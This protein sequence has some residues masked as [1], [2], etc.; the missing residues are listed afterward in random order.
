VPP[1]A[2]TDLGKSMMRVGA[3]VCGWCEKEFV[4]EHS[5]TGSRPILASI[6]KTDY[7]LREP[8]RIPSK[9]TGA[10]SEWAEI[11]GRR[12]DDPPA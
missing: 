2:V 12:E 3:S 10:C 11:P 6:Q 8:G 1:R 4:K 7:L 9:L 5:A